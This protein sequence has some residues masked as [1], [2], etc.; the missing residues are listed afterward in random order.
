MNFFYSDG[1]AATYVYNHEVM[2]SEGTKRGR[3]SFSSENKRFLQDYIV[4][5]S[6]HKY[7]L[8]SG[9]IWELTDNGQTDV[10]PVAQLTAIFSLNENMFGFDGRCFVSINLR[11]G[12]QG[13]VLSDASLEN[14]TY[15]HF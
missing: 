1:L 3:C 10:L 5:C 12:K 11:T 7:C 6:G 4:P 8:A 13:K 15:V 9:H 2:T 14:Y